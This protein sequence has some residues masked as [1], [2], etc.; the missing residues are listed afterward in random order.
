MGNYYRINARFNLDDEEERNAEQ[1]GFCQRK[2]Q[3][4]GYFGKDEAKAGTDLQIDEI[5]SIETPIIL[6]NTL[7]VG[8]AW[9]AVTKYML[10]QNDDIGL[11][12]GTV[13]CVITECNDGRIN[14]I[15]GLHVTEENVRDAIEAAD[16]DF[17]E[18]AVGG[19]TGVL[20][21]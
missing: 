16:V 7:N 8:V 2:R 20:S 21:L 19:G 1:H 9:N 14:D 3:N 10:E 12:T 13:N 11:T 18:G 17:A 5:G 4:I 6:T 15:R